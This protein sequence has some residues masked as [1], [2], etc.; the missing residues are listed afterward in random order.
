[1]EGQPPRCDDL[2]G[3]AVHRYLDAGGDA[4]WLAHCG[5]GPYAHVRVSVQ[6]ALALLVAGW[7]LAGDLWGGRGDRLAVPGEGRADGQGAARM[8]CPARKGFTGR[9][10]PEGAGAC[11]RL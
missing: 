3:R 8:R 11:G 5:Q 9:V 7:C 10:S 2:S 4:A 6:D 1:M